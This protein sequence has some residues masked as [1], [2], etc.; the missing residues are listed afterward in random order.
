MHYTITDIT[1]NTYVKTPPNEIIIKNINI[2]LK[3]GLTKYSTIKIN[4]ISFQ[5]ITYDYF[6]NNDNFIFSSHLDQ[7]QKRY[8]F[9]LPEDESFNLLVSSLG[10]FYGKALK[11]KN[12]LKNI[13]SEIKNETLTFKI[14]KDN[15]I[16]MIEECL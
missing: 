2:S 8:S 4:C 9:N 1:N 13:S 3:T 12:V 7:N 14:F 11:M 10:E 15:Y 6:C 16:S 5:A